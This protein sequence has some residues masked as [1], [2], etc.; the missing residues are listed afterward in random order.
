MICIDCKSKNHSLCREQKRQLD[1][2]LS[3]AERLGSQWCDCQHVVDDVGKLYITSV[4]HDWQTTLLIPIPAA[5][6]AVSHHRSKLD[7]AARD[8]IPAHITISYPF[9]PPSQINESLLGSLSGMFGKIP[10]FRFTLDQIGWFGDDV[11]WLGPSDPAPFNVFINTVFSAFPSC[12]PYGGK[13]TQVIP[14]LTIGNTGEQQALQTAAESIK[15]YLPIDGIATE[16]TLMA[17][18]CPG[19]PDTPPGQWHVIT[20]F[21]LDHH[22]IENV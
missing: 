15:S 14:H 9:L 10:A 21:P 8:G 13:Y 3:D 7:D 11:V 2:T 17:G 1:Q 16:V 5:E 18:P 4:N 22:E 20:T 12:P 6:A 19:S